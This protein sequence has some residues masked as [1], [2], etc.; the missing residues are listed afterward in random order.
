MSSGTRRVPTSVF[1][2]DIDEWHLTRRPSC[3][4]TDMMVFVSQ[5]V[6]GCHYRHK[7]ISFPISSLVSLYVIECEKE[8]KV[9]YREQKL[10][11]IYLLLR[12]RHWYQMQPVTVIPF[13]QLGGRA[14]SSSPAAPHCSHKFLAGALVTYIASRL[15]PRPQQPSSWH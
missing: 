8:F 9:L 1:C 15:A 14:A 2:E 11:S 6:S 10:M 7:D 13:Y 3:S 4:L 5:G 12:K